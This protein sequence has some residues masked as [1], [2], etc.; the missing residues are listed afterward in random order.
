MGIP[1]NSSNV[2]GILTQINL[3]SQIFGKRFLEFDVIKK[4]VMDWRRS[5]L[6]NIILKLCDYMSYLNK[7]ILIIKEWIE[8][9]CNYNLNYKSEWNINIIVLLK[10]KTIFIYIFIII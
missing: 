10:E 5:P 6:S 8:H 7:T 3:N 1:Y 9:L 2:P 4:T